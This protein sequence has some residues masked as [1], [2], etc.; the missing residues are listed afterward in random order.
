M[1]KFVW[2]SLFFSRKKS[3]LLI[4]DLR[5]M[6]DRD[7]DHIGRVS[8]SIQRIPPDKLDDLHYK[9]NHFS[10]YFHWGES[11]GEGS[12]GK[13]YRIYSIDNPQESYAIKLFPLRELDEVR[14]EAIQHE[15]SITDEFIIPYVV[16][17][18]GCGPIYNFIPDN[19]VPIHNK[20]KMSNE[21][22]GILMEYIPGQNLEEIRESHDNNL[23]FFD[24]C[25]ILEL[26]R[27]TLIGLIGLHSLGLAHRDI[28]AENIMFDGHNI[29]IVDLGLSCRCSG[30]EHQD[31]SCRD[32]K[33]TPLYMP[34]E[35]FLQKEIGLSSI[36]ASDIWAFGVTFF[37]LIYAVYPYDADDFETFVDKLLQN[38]RT[39]V[40]DPKDI[41]ME[42]AQ[43]I[44][45]LALQPIDQR[46]TAKELLQEVYIL[47]D[48]LEVSDNTDEDDGAD[49][50]RDFEDGTDEERD[51]EEGTEEETEEETEEGT[52]E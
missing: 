2:I 19:S 26:M 38:D 4:Q 21:Y 5:K 28:K 37:Y 3:R 45:E 15:A 48:E 51:V 50:E 30:S 40:P 34:P 46:P 16:T 49:E 47:L 22:Y 10:E 23:D 44:I 39:A 41:Q 42:N 24:E 13:I 36:Q 14:F 31:Y 33:G 20:H 6:D 11:L 32:R 9:L 18:Y 17:Y 25:F 52:E 29:K 35:A 43:Y 12:F 27:Q 7:V 8:E 1:Q